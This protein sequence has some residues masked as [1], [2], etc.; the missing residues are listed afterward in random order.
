MADETAKKP[1]KILVEWT[2]DNI[3]Y[4]A[5]KVFLNTGIN[6]IDVTAWERVR[7][8]VE[9]I[10]A[11]DK[12]SLSEVALKEGRIIEQNAEVAKATKQT[13]PATVKA[14]ESLTDMTVAKAVKTVG[15]CNS[16]ATL[17]SWKASESRDEVRLAI[18]AKIDAINGEK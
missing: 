18:I 5:D 3:K 9:D 15:N 7:W 10:L 8:M 14:A 13:A 1:T 16:L 17:E 6:E 2:G 4:I 11:T 12:D